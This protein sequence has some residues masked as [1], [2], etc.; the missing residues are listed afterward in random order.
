MKAGGLTCVF[1]GSEKMPGALCPECGRIAGAILKVEGQRD[2]FRLWEP[3]SEHRNFDDA[4]KAAGEL[5]DRGMEEDFCIDD[6]P[7]PGAKW[8]GTL[9]PSY[10]MVKEKCPECGD[11]TR[12][13]DMIRTTDYH[14]I[15]YRRVC[16][17]CYERIMETKGY[18]GEK[19]DERDE[20]LDYDY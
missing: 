5:F 8:P 16:M 7:R 2:V 4:L 20:N 11:E 3:I 18:D 1:C 6:N 15:P 14:G 17:K 19:Y 13:F 9:I 10:K 12:A